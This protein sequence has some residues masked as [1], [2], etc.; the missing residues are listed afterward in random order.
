[1]LEFNQTLAL[2]IFIS[3]Y[4]LIISNKVNKTLAAM[5]GAVLVVVTGVIPQNEVVQYINWE[6]IGLLAGMFI[7]VAGLREAGFFRWVGLHMAKSVDH[8]PITMFFVLPVI[9]ACLSSF[10]DAVTV[11]LIMAALTIEILDTLE[12]KPTP[13]IIAEICA[14]NIGGSATMLS[15]PPNVVIGTSLGY[16]LTDF[17]INTGPISYTA[18]T[19]ILLVMY[20]I[21]RGFI[22]K[23]VEKHAIHKK[24]LT[25]NPNDAIKDWRLL[26]IGLGS[27]ILVVILLIVHN[28]IHISIA[29]S[30]LFA[31][32]I[33]LAFDLKE[34]KDILRKVDWSIL[35]FFGGLFVIIGGLKKTGILETLAQGISGITGNNL[36]VAVS[37]I[38]WMTAF[39]SILVD[40]VA[41]VTTMVPVVAYMSDPEFVSLPLV[42]EPLA[43]SLA[44]GTCMGGNATPFGTASNV[45][46][47]SVSSKM[48]HPVSW[49]YFFKISFPVTVIALVV[50]NVLLILRYGL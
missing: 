12:I 9:T 41:L 38:L 33:I 27:L 24:R 18:L 37:I 45:A 11:I 46:G 50:C 39:L 2:G 1:M 21:Y 25:H 19:V 42:R 5:I 20:V 6:C 26:K 31:A 43:W 40:N 14:A 3:A 23:G 22:K 7:I 48:K 4:A 47:L 36:I 44:L 16:S 35:G 10:L 32:A 17:I 49:K 15:D 34:S 29:A 13:F 8:H 30:A 28:T